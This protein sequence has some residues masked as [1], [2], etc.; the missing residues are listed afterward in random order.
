MAGD[1]SGESVSEKEWRRGRCSKS[2]KKLKI[3]DLSFGK[4]SVST[5][6]GMS[7]RTQIHDSGNDIV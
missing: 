3:R 7:T 6:I 5:L 1:D 4:R 2:E